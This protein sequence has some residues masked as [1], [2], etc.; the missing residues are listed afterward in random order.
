MAKEIPIGANLVLRNSDEDWRLVA[1]W[2][3]E[4][5]QF[6]RQ[7]VIQNLHSGATRRAFKH[8]LFEKSTSTYQELSDFFEEQVSQEMQDDFLNNSEMSDAHETELDIKALLSLEDTMPKSTT[9]E[10]TTAEPPRKRFKG[11]SNEDV[12]NLASKTTEATTNRQTKWAIKL[13]K[14]E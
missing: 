2:D 9:M 14:G 10:S 13:L 5:P 12:E 7:Y 4:V 8:E 3:N 6:C 1:Y 11:V